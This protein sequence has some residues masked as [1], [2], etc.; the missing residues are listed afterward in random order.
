MLIVQLE[1]IDLEATFVLIVILEYN[2]RSFSVTF[3]LTDKDSQY[4]EIIIGVSRENCLKGQRGAGYILNKYCFVKVS[5]EVLL[6][7]S[8][9]S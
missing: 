5:L 4:T 1:Y 3:N 6:S 8:P 7:F 2:N 9:A